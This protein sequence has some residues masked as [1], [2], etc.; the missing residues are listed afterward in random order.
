MRPKLTTIANM[1]FRRLDLPNDGVIDRYNGSEVEFIQTDNQSVD[2]I[3]NNTV[4]NELIIENLDINEDMKRMDDLKEKDLE[5]VEIDSKAEKVEIKCEL[6]VA[7]CFHKYIFGKEAKVKERIE[8]KTSAKIIIPY[9]SDKSQ[10]I[11]IKGNK[12]SVKSAEREI[13]LIIDENRPNVDFTHFV[14]IPF[15]L[16]TIRDRFKQFREEVMNNK[17]CVRSQGFD[18]SLFESSYKLH[19]TIAP[20]LLTNE[21]EKSLA[22]Q[23]LNECYENFLKTS[24]IKDK[25]IRVRVKGIDCMN[26]DP[27]QVHVIYAKITDLSQ[28][29]SFQI[30]INDIFSH[31]E[32]TKLMTRSHQFERLDPNK[33]IKPHITLMN[34]KRRKLAKSDAYSRNDRKREAFDA[35][36]IL[37]NFKDFDFGEVSLESIQISVRYGRDDGKDGY[38]SHISRIDLLN[39]SK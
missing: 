3:N 39:E 5:E 27:T 38:Y 9:K 31:F 22:S 18:E 4:I 24:V 35:T 33:K 36:A 17:E 10:I 20:L 16:K 6:W 19:L 1:I 12:Q 29:N 37:D 13:N 21:S 15:N 7:K 8:R 23:V 14:S 28:N 11:I 2:N 30:I 26:D 34:T 32:G 25:Q